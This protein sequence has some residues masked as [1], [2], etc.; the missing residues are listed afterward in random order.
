MKK[1]GLLLVVVLGLVACLAG[2]A[3]AFF[4]IDYNEKE[5]FE[6]TVFVPCANDGDGEWVQFTGLRHVKANFTLN[7]KVYHSRFHTQPMGVSGVGEDTGDTYR[8]TGGHREIYS[9]SFGPPYRQTIVTNYRVIGPG[10]G[11]NSVLHETWH[12]TVNANG[13]YTA[14]VGNVKVDCK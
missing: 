2:P 10:P 3:W 11:N 5:P 1:M 7:G 4:N 13:D 6:V 8:L 12:I 14:E 9:D